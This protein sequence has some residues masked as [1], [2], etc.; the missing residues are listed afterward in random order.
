[1]VSAPT[2]NVA[3]TTYLVFITLGGQGIVFWNGTSWVPSE[4]RRWNGTAW[5]KLVIRRWNGSLWIPL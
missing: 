5:T 4:F 3:V 1:M 2:I